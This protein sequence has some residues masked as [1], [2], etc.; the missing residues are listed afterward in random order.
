MTQPNEYLVID[1]GTAYY[2]IDDVLHSSPVNTD[3]SIDW[4]EPCQVDFDRI[5]FE[6]SQECRAIRQALRIIRGNR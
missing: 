2:L 5:S 1:G 4:D 3:G 6:E